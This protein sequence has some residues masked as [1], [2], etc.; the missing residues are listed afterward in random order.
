M[1]MLWRFPN[2]SLTT[3]YL[4]SH[5]YIL[6]HKC[7]ELLCQRPSLQSLKD[8]VIP[9]LAKF[10]YRQSYV[11]KWGL[12]INFGTNPQE[13]AIAHSTTPFSTRSKNISS[14]FPLSDSAISHSATGIGSP[15]SSPLSKAL[16]RHTS[17]T[18]QSP[19]SGHLDEPIMSNFRV[20]VRLHTLK[21][22]YTARVNTIGAY[23][24]L[25]RQMLAATAAAVAT[26][27]QPR[28]LATLSQPHQGQ[29]SSDSVVASSARIGERASIK[30][31]IVGPHCVIGKNV[32]LSGCTLMGYVEVKDGAKLENCIVSRSVVVAERATLKDCELAPGVVTQSEGKSSIVKS[33]TSS[34]PAVQVVEPTAQTSAPLH[35][36]GVPKMQ[37]SSSAQFKH[38]VAPKGSL[39]STELSPTPPG[40][41]F[42]SPIHQS[43]IYHV[44]SIDLLMVFAYLLALIVSLKGERMSTW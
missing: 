15:S 22:G 27:G 24:E 11:K 9:W 18:A 26:S 35:K 32:K 8:D 29:I 19:T 12:P 5:V 16:Q 21:D 1:S 23:A 6:K 2:V 17:T 31:S 34:P 33:T 4:D 20:S 37:D 13:L 25:N 42:P 7:L 43:P 40:A 41:F 36:A 10:S 3:R 44:E 14:H 28:N 39:D 30:K 38:D